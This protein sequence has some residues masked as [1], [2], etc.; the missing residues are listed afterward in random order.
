MEMVATFIKLK[1]ALQENKGEKSDEK[2]KTLEKKWKMLLVSATK[3]T[4]DGVFCLY[5][6]FGCGERGWSDGWQ[7][8]SGLV[9]AIC[10]TYKLFIK[11]Q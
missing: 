10:G 7:T 4:A 9:A 3:L 6:V 1:R 11:C 2:V 8:I 5:D